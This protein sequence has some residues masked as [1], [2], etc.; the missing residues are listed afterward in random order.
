MASIRLEVG[1]VRR[2]DLAID[3]HAACGGKILH[4]SL[5]NISADQAPSLCGRLGAE[6]KSP[7][8]FTSAGPTLAQSFIVQF[9]RQGRKIREMTIKRPTRVPKGIFKEITHDIQSGK[10]T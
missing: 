7:Q 3:H 9:L 8:E 1:H 2:P 4:T 10:G 5:R 6:G